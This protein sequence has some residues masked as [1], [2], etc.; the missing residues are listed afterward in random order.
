MHTIHKPIFTGIFFS[1]FPETSKKHM[2][3]SQNQIDDSFALDFI[4]FAGELQAKKISPE[5]CCL[6][7]PE[8]SDEL[9]I[10][11]AA[12]LTEK[13]FHRNSEQALDS[14]KA[15][16]RESAARGQLFALR[17]KN[18]PEIIAAA[19][20]IPVLFDQ[21]TRRFTRAENTDTVLLSSFCV[22]EKSRGRS[23]GLVLLDHLINQARK[24]IG[25]DGQKY[26][27]IYLIVYDDNVS[28]KALYEKRFERIGAYLPKDGRTRSKMRLVL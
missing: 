18:S 27:A 9:L 24:S 13:C 25:P 14:K 21:E 17:V 12:R 5:E 26:K 7:T 22:S 23:I 8:Q 6:L 19:Y 10:E 15:E 4:H 20:L 2:P 1:N 11:Q 28:A 16:M 3:G